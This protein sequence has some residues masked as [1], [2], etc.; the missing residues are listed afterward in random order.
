MIRAKEV[1]R[2]R[3]I[4]ND[5]VVKERLCS[6]NT[7]TSYFR[8]RWATEV[9]YTEEAYLVPYIN[10]MKLYSYG[11]EVAGA[12]VSTGNFTVDYAGKKLTMVKSVTVNYTGDITDLGLGNL[13]GG[14]YNEVTKVGITPPISVTAGDTVEITYEATFS[15]SASELGGVLS[16]AS[17]YDIELLSRLLDRLSNRAYKSMTVLKV[18][19]ASP[20]GA[21]LTL[22]TANDTANKRIVVPSTTLTTPVELKEIVML[23]PDLTSLF[24]FVKATTTSMPAGSVFSLSVKVE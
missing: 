23:A 12:T 8:D 6:G 9:T 18:T 19:L 20:E 1:V 16:D 22:N 17:V 4:R 7:L 2:L 5:I 11:Y 10:Y 3:V 14:T 24:R 15:L 21:V 13:Y